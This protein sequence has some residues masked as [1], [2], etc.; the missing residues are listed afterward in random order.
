MVLFS[1]TGRV[2]QAVV[3]RAMRLYGKYVDQI[4]LKASAAAFFVRHARYP[5]FGTNATDN[6]P[7]THIWFCYR[8]YSKEIKAPMNFH[9]RGYT[10]V[11][12]PQ[13]MHV[14]W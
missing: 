4:F 11:V 9:Q 13:G 14:C 8:F 3:R 6:P 2:L 5:K 1:T 7:K 10:Y 12:P